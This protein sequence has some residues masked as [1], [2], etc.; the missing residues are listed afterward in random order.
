MAGYSATPLARKLGIAAGAELLLIDAPADYR[1]IVAPLPQG[2]RLVNRLSS[3]TRM[4]HLFAT[5]ERDLRSA[6]LRLRP[7][8][9]A[10]ATVWV[11][12]PKKTSRVATDITEDTIRE[13]ALP[14][15]FVD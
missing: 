9:E 7:R 11:S 6:L 5:R 1:Q 8:I 10:D 4:V 12:W 3:R 14:L 13:V 15:G 2:V